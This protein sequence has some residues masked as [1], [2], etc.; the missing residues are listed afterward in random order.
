MTAK[1]RAV[2]AKALPV[3]RLANRSAALALALC[4]GPALGA[5]PPVDADLPTPAPGFAAALD[6]GPAPA[7]VQP[8]RDTP[9]E[10]AIAA[11]VVARLMGLRLLDS[12]A[13]AQDPGRAAAAIRGFQTGIGVKPTGVLDRKTLALMGL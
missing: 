6:T 11:L 5:M 7:F 1:P 13:D 12:T 3:G 10:P 9:L 8:K 2:R 4:A